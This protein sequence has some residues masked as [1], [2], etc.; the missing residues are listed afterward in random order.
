MTTHSTYSNAVTGSSYST[1]IDNNHPYFLSSSDSLGMSLTTIILNEQNYSQ[2]SRSMKVALSSKK[3]L[4]FVDGSNLQPPLNSPLVNHWNRC[5]HMVISWLLNSISPDIRNNI[6]YMN[7]AHLIWKELATQYAQ[8]NLPKLFNLRKEIVQLSQ[9]SMNV[10]A[11]YTK[12]KTLIDELDNLTSRPRC[13]CR[14][15]SCDVNN[16]LSVYDLNIQLMQF[17]MGLNDV[18]ASIRGQI[19]LMNPIPTLS[20][21]YAMLLQ[22]ENQRDVHNLDGFNYGNVALN[23]RSNVQGKFT[24]KTASSAQNSGGFLKKQNVDSTL[25]CE[26]CHM[27][28]HSKDK[29]FCV[30]GYPSWHRL[31]GKPKP[32]PRLGT[33]QRADAALVTA[34]DGSV[35]SDVIQSADVSGSGSSHGLTDSQFKNLVH[36]L[37]TNMKTSGPETTSWSS[38]NTVHVAGTFFASNTIYVESQWIID[39]GTTDHITARLDILINPV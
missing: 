5:N 19:L 38:A 11:Y 12:Y 17:L 36:L 32:K 16:K 2:W 24:N 25:V 9:G 6:V 4:G 37:Q 20:Q 7:S 29:C 28:G 23:V 14:K 8:S 33:S 35:S 30:V 34:S 22:E 39:S 18:F 1:V 27:S 31:Y 13:D 26:Y 3:N 10:T 21:C 15:C